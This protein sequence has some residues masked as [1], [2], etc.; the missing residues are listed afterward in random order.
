MDL[1]QGFKDKVS[2]VSNVFVTKTGTWAKIANINGSISDSSRE[3]EKKYAMLGRAFAEC[4]YD[5]TTIDEIEDELASLADDDARKEV[6]NA[7]L[8]ARQAEDA[9]DNLY[10]EKERLR[11]IRPCRCCGSA[12]DGYM[13]YCP[14]CGTAVVDK[15]DEI[16]RSEIEVIVDE[17]SEAAEEVAK[18]VAGELADDVRRYMNEPADVEKKRD[19]ADTEAQDKADEETQDEAG[20]EAQDDTGTE[21]ESKAEAGTGSDK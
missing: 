19:E 15:T 4:E 10:A 11:G 8:A 6:I 14:F 12:V 3:V 2:Y 1:W 17:D 20:G 13:D 16:L 9:L 5:D 18:D 21:A 7:V